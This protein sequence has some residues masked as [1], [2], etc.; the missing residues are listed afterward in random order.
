MKLIFKRKDPNSKYYGFSKPHVYSIIYLTGNAFQDIGTL[1]HEILHLF[2]FHWHCSNV[3]AEGVYAKGGGGGAP[4]PPQIAPYDPG[5]DYEAYIKYG[6]QVATTQ[7]GVAPRFAQ[8]ELDLLRQ[9]GGDITEQMQRIEA[10]TYPYTA[11]LQEGL[12]KLASER[13]SGGLTPELRNQYLEQLRSELGPNVGSPIGADYVGRGMVSL[14]EEFNRYYQN[15][16]LSLTG[17]LPLATPQAP[18]PMYSPQGLTPDQ[19][20]QSGAQGY[21]SYVNAIAS[22]YGAQAAASNRGGG[23]G[24]ALGAGLGF[25]SKLLP[26]FCWVAKEVFGSWSDP[27]VNQVRKF[28]ILECPLWIT[29]L[30]I[31]YGKQMA[32]FIS[33]KP[34]LKAVAKKIFTNLA[35]RGKSYGKY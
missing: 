4:A 29:N 15:L 1:T 27:R 14:G 32:Q 23:G 2:N 30:Y 10:Q 5:K 17:R 21:G 31:K 26:M 18:R 20:L 35:K 16:G 25:A 24:G 11:S 6:P 12:G 3:V 34:M 8:S 7:I 9:Y 22:M 33:N 19:G 13:S 28:F